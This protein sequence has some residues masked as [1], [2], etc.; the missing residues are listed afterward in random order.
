MPA[1]DMSL[2]VRAFIAAAKTCESIV[3]RLALWCT[4]S[5]G[6]LRRASRAIQRSEYFLAKSTFCLTF[7][8]LIS[9]QAALDV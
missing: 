6:N 4:A 8:K 2:P 3:S 9:T 7:C 5:C 1:T